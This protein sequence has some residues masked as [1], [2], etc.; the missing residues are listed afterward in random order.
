MKNKGTNNT[1][2]NLKIKKRD[3]LTTEKI[4][5]GNFSANKISDDL[6]SLEVAEK[7]NIK[8]PLVNE[9]PQIIEDSKEMLALKL[10]NPFRGY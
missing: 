10:A 6:K 5:L 4:N 1:N 3:Y 7:E 9:N 8:T 2:Q